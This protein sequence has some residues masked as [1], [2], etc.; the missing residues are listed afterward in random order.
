[1]KISGCTQPRSNIW[2][3]KQ[4]L[5]AQ[6]GDSCLGRRLCREPGRWGRS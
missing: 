4:S 6:Q 2:K 5:P 3:R 1:M